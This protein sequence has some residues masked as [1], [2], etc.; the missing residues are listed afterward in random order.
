[1]EMTGDKHCVKNTS[2]NA[3]TA[4]PEPVLYFENFTVKDRW[5]HIMWNC[6]DPCDHC[7]GRGRYRLSN[8]FHEVFGVQPAASLSKETVF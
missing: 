5:F 8:F 3:E 2:D 1:M 6:D 4:Y 7:F